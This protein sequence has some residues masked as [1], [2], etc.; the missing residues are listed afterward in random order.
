VTAYRL[1]MGQY[2]PPIHVKQ[3]ESGSWHVASPDP[4]PLL[5]NNPRVQPLLREWILRLLSDAPE[6][7]GTATQ[8][9]EALEAAADEKVPEFQPAAPPSAVASP[10][11]APTPAGG[12]VLPERPRP[13]SPARASRPWLALAA[14]GV[15]AVLLWSVQPVPV[16]CEH[17]SE[18][19]PRAS[20][21][22]APGAGTAAVGDTSPTEPQASTHPLSEPKPIAQEPPPE[23]HPRQARPDEKGRCPGRKQ[24]VLNGGCWAENPS[25]NSEECAE[26]GYVLL[27]GK[28]FA[29]ALEPPQKPPPTSSPAKAR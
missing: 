8:L 14:A 15:C 4:R 5:E 6:V 11:N 12:G 27:R 9:A 29:P 26:N 28:C 2:P 22:Q 13:L 23:P 21:S 10:P 3:D 17:L 24:V 18:S 7:R 1:A 25:M 20:D 16:P 19:T